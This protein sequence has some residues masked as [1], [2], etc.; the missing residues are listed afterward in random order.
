MGDVIDFNAKRRDA[1]KRQAEAST[2]TTAPDDKA[3]K[4]MASVH[5]KGRSVNMV[6]ETSGGHVTYG[7][8]LDD[9]E[10]LA[11]QLIRHVDEIRSE[12]DRLAGEWDGLVT[13]FAIGSDGLADP[14]LGTFNGRV[15]GAAAVA[16]EVLVDFN[17][18]FGVPEFMAVVDDDGN[19][20]TKGVRLNGQPL[21]IELS[22]AS[23][24]DVRRFLIGELR[25]KKAVQPP[26]EPSAP[27]P[28]SPSTT[29]P[30]PRRAPRKAPR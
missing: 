23:V 30:K 24:A 21:D 27:P 13:A 20:A 25:L 14:F 11:G 19:V 12:L 22:T 2:G 18:A 6:I 15:L 16:N 4:G 1:Q 8:S 5:R 10:S 9:A 17:A 26:P 7:L 3:P 28:T 29:P